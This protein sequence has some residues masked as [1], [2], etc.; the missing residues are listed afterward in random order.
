MARHSSR[1][2]ALDEVNGKPLRPDAGRHG[3]RSLPQSGN[4]RRLAYDERGRGWRWQGTTSKGSFFSTG[5]SAD[6]PPERR[7]STSRRG[8]S[9]SRGLSTAIIVR[10][11]GGISSRLHVT[12]PGP[13]DLSTLHASRSVRQDVE[14]CA[15]G[16]R[17]GPR[18]WCATPPRMLLQRDEGHPAPNT[19]DGASPK[20]QHA[21]DWSLVNCRSYGISLRKKLGNLRMARSGHAARVPPNA[22]MQT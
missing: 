21:F 9:V 4:R 15:E 11:A 17:R 5:W 13:A 14:P 22:R 16:E 20:T 3:P 1:L 19:P 8:R 12:A 18:S 10:R 7:K 6:R 2:P